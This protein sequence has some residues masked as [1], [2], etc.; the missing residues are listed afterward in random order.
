VACDRFPAADQAELDEVVEVAAHR[1]SG[2][3]ELVCEGRRGDGAT[4][5]DRLEHA[6][7][8]ARLE[9]LRLGRTVLAFVSGDKHNTDVT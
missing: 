4:L 6:V 1:R 8:R 2:Q 9:D 3:A 7:A 5:A